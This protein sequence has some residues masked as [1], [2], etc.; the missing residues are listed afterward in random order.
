MNLGTWTETFYGEIAKRKSLDLKK[1]IVGVG[2]GKIISWTS[3][4]PDILYELPINEM[5]LLAKKR[6][7]GKQEIGVYILINTI[8]ADCQIWECCFTRNINT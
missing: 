8:N 7:D 5:D 6:G 1:Y 2:A 4:V 3:K